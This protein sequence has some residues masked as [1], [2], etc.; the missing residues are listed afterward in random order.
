MDKEPSPQ[1]EDGQILERAF[2]MMNQNPNIAMLHALADEVINH[3]E[4]DTKPQ[5]LRAFLSG[6]DALKGNLRV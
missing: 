4:L 3:Y 5:L 2:I 1:E 6:V